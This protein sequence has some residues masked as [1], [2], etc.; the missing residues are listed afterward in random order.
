[1]GT[2]V[3]Y[4]LCRQTIEECKAKEDGH[5]SDKMLEETDARSIAEH[6]VY[7]HRVKS[8]NKLSDE[9]W[10][11]IGIEAVVVLQHNSNG[12]M[13]AFGDIEGSIAIWETAVIPSYCCTLKLSDSYK[14]GRNYCCR[15]LSWSPSGATLF[16]C[17]ELLSISD[18]VYVAGIWDIRSRDLV[19]LIR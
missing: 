6:T 18:T 16:A 13:C 9:P 11:R 5:K 14:D 3:P 10:E 8:A 12:S 17:Y 19:N 7:C 2:A 4:L 15:H 1:M